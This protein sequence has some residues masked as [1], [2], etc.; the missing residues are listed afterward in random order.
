MPEE[1][2]ALM[3]NV[4]NRVMAMTAAKW[5]DLALT[6]TEIDLD[7]GEEDLDDPDMM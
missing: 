3:L 6:G 2:T 4:N 1:D 5:E 7:E